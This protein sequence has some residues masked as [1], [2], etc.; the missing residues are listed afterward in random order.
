MNKKKVKEAIKCLLQYG[1]MWGYPKHIPKDGWDALNFEDNIPSYK[2][3]PHFWGGWVGYISYE[4]GSHFESLPKRKHNDLGLPDAYFMQ[5]YRVIVYD[6]ISSQLK[7][8]IASVPNNDNRDYDQY[9]DEINKFWMKFNSNFSDN[10]IEKT[11]PKINY[12]INLNL[13]DFQSNLSSEDYKDR[14]SRIKVYIREGD[15]YQANIA[16]RFETELRSI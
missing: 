16:Q 8:I 3:L 7:Y 14:V 4:A 15:I 1:W 5:V 13:N 6:H 9:I 10:S 2:N 12:S 11:A